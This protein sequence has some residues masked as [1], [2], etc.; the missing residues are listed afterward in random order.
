MLT[1]LLDFSAV[2]L[3]VFF[4]D[5]EV[6]GILVI[7]QETVEVERHHA[8]DEFLTAHPLQFAEHDG[9]V[10][11]D[12][13][14]VDV[15]VLDAVDVVEELFLADLLAGG[16]DAFLEGT[17]HDLFDSL[18]F[19]LFAQINETEAD[20]TFIGATRTARA[21]H[22]GLDVVGK[23][24]INDV[25]QFLHVDATGGHVGGDEQLQRAFAEVVHHVVAHAL[26]QVAMQGSGVVAVLDE[27][28]GNLLRFELGAAEDDAVDGWCVV[29]D[30][31]QHR[32]AV[33]GGHHVIDVV[34]VGGA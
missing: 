4:V 6:D 23:V 11:V 26:R 15:D 25:R 17:S 20:A 3:L 2:F 10:V 31:F 28:V 24:V 19:A 30:A 22:I 7:I 29:D 5:V 32:V 14:A 12:L 16:D 27:V 34:D 21:V 8:G 33:L 13:L 18:D 9:Q 1:L